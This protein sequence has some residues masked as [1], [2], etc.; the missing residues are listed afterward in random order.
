M[1]LKNSHQKPRTYVHLICNPRRETSIWKIPRE[2]TWI[3]NAKAKAMKYY[4]LD[5][6]RN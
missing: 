3:K 4:L 1:A 6:K 2:K 5:A